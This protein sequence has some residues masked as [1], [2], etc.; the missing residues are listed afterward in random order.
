M[1]F[2][3]FVKDEFVSSYYEKETWSAET[4]DNF[5]HLITR[6]TEVLGGFDAWASSAGLR[7]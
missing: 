2:E 7:C 6:L 5:E 1:Q 3:E 4:K